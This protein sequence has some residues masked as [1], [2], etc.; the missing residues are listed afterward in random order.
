MTKIASPTLAALATIFGSAALAGGAYVAV[1]GHEVY[2][3]VHG[4]LASGGTPVLVLH[5]GMMSID[6]AFADLIPVLAQERP[7]IGIDQQGHGR[8]GDRE[9]A[10]TLATMREDTLGVLDHL[11]VERAHVV[12]FSMGGMLGLD[13]A[14]NAPER[15]ASL[16]AI[17]ASN[18][19][20][21]MVPEIRA[22]NEDP[23][24]EPS[25]EALALMP[26]EADFA[27]MQA[28][29][30]ENPSGPAVFETTMA[31]LHALITSD[32][33]WSEEELAAIGAPVLLLLGDTDFVIPQHAAEMAETIPGAGLA[34]L[35]DT[36]HMT[37]LARPELPDLIAAQIDK[38]E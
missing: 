20:A 25:P 5:G 15:V 26:T 4:D 1:D 18:G 11:G 6:T 7:V 22:M 34:I 24:A 8:T 14:V 31:K 9:G 28:A 32:W 16:V 30:A 36:T 13:L 2:H 17:S 33:G 35:P 38:A 21:G 3:E 37:I 29:V 10:I 23:T 27:E 19:T 12:G